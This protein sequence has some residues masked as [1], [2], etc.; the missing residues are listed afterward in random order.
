MPDFNGTIQ[1]EDGDGLETIL[2][3]DSGRLIAKAGE[4]ELGNWAV[5]E[6]EME[7]RNGE[8]RIK[9]EGEELIVGVEDPAGFTEILGI[10]E[11]KPK[12]GRQKKPRT[13]RVKRKD[14]KRA[15]ANLVPTA[16]AA[17]VVVAP[18]SVTE[19]PPPSTNGAVSPPE[20]GPSLWARIPLRAKLAG[21]V[22]IGL[23]AFFFL[24]PNLLALLL[25]LAGVATLF[26]AIAAKS[27]SGTGVLP[28]PFFATTTAIAGGI[29]SV[30]LAMIIMVIT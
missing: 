1:L 6:L 20:E 14:R 2:T 15:E 24:A 19:P 7:R 8:F 4:H 5:G 23:V 27:E 28:P 21:L 29:G 30:V 13:P 18:V 10:N 25:M 11:A 17:P 26:L 12:E 9:V 3:V 22:V 16:P